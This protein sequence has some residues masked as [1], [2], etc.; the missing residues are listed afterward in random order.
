MKRRNNKV[1]II[2]GRLRGRLVE[3]NDHKDLRP[4]G[5]RLRETMFSW[6]QTQLPGSRCLDMF[7]G[8]GVLGFEAM[9]RGA[10]SAILFEKSATV[11]EKIRNNADTLGV[12]GVHIVTGDV[13]DVD[14][15]VSWCKPGSI[16]IAFLDP[17]FA[18]ELQTRAVDA[19]YKTTVLAD[20]ASIVI[21]SDKRQRPIKPP[22]GWLQLREK[23]AG[24]VRM[25]LYRVTD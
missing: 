12:A 1:R 7:A 24:D 15:L 18:D 25:Q 22:Q 10:E 2:A 14:L 17:P 6:L 21:E 20:Q 23:A 13:L 3:F 8:S 4:T 19:L 16:D 5:D 9:S 11:A